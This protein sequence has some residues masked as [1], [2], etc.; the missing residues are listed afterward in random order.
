M[1]NR[2][3]QLRKASGLTLEQL[4]ESAGT[5]AQQISRLE[6]SERRLTA[7]WLAR[8]APA[9]KVTP[10]DLLATASL[11][12]IGYVGAGATIYPF[13]D[14][15]PGAGLDDIEIPPGIDPEKAVAL[16]VRGDS[17]VPA[18]YDGDVLIYEDRSEEPLALVG[19]ECVV[20]LADGRTYIKRIARGSSPGFWTLRSYNASDIEDV[21]IEWAAR[22]K[23]IHRA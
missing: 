21:V 20:K 11:P 4:A 5:S 16:F 6:K 13:D 12:V 2:L 23:W 1:N 9:L 14:H 17:M 19:R 15:A 22:V 8:L 18:Y 3:R 10:R 7:D